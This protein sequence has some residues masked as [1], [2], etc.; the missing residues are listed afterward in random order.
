MNAVAHVVAG[1]R[2]RTTPVR[3]VGAALLAVTAGIHL[4]LW[5]IG[6]RGIDII[7]PL[8]LANGVGGIVLALGLLVVPGRWLPLTAAAGGLFELGTLGGLIVS[9]TV[10]LFGFKETWQAPLV[11]Q[12]I[13]VEALGALILGG[14]AAS[15]LFRARRQD[16]QG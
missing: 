4:H 7:G 6:Y 11:P 1:G 8:F 15:A 3:L 2:W 9:A 13:V 12:S 10:G 14:Y 16:F 5:E